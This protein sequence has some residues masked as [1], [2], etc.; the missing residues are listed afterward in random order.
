MLTFSV[1]EDSDDG[2]MYI[3]DVSENA[4]LGKSFVACEQAGRHHKV[5]RFNVVLEVAC[6]GFSSTDI[7][8]DHSFQICYFDGR[9][10]LKPFTIQDQVVYGVVNEIGHDSVKIDL[11]C[12][13]STLRSRR[14][15]P[16][17]CEVMGR[18]RHHL[19]VQFW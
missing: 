14:G 6:E 19:E 13:S 16:H 15:P 1:L 12:F 5:S 17:G 4:H 11:A 8:R 7:L 18:R 10:D 2:F 9:N 3:D